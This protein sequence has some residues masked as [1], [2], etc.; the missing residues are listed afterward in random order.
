[1][2]YSEI[3]N[4]FYEQDVVKFS[5][6]YDLFERAYEELKEKLNLTR[7]EKNDELIP[8]VIIH[9]NKMKRFWNSLGVDYEN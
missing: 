6:G 3:V 8:T 2:K 9:T 4:M 7:E 1:M 5:K